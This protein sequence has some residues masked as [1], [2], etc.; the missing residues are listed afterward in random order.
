MYLL[1]F[2]SDGQ[3]QLQF[4]LSE[5]KKEELILRTVLRVNFQFTNRAP[6][7]C[8]A[9]LSHQNDTEITNV[10]IR[11]HWVEFQIA[12]VISV[13]VKKGQYGLH[14][15]KIRTDCSN[16]VSVTTSTNDL[17]MQPLLVVSSYDTSISSTSFLKNILDEQ[18]IDSPGI[19]SKRSISS[20]SSSCKIH[21]VTVQ[22][23][24]LNQISFLDGSIIAPPE[25]NTNICGGS[26]DTRVPRSPVHAAVFN[27]LV[28]AP[29]GRQPFI[30]GAY[31][32]CCV[33]IA[34]NGISLLIEKQ[35]PKYEVIKIPNGVVSECGCIHVL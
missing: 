1:F 25:Y 27:R 12:N 7:D 6:T 14:G 11:E 19:V 17:N 35:N 16:D 26:C 20:A 4:N 34:Y 29:A 22:T 8:A 24:W 21:T 31:R 33:P 5:I 28:T 10:I 3:G 23:A 30:S 9:H 2:C 15:F 13:W 18:G 32:K